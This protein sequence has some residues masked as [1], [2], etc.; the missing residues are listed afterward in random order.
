MHKGARTDPCGGRGVTRVPTATQCIG[1]A[2]TLGPYKHLLVGLTLR[3]V[4]DP[5]ERSEV[6]RQVW[7]SSRNSSA[8]SRRLAFLQSHL[9]DPQQARSPIAP[10]D[11]RNDAK[12]L[13]YGDVFLFKNY[14]LN[15]RTAGIFDTDHS[16]CAVLSDTRRKSQ[17]VAGTP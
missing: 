16:C 3:I 1:R 14:A 12:R 7:Q 9:G 5:S 4:C 2:E 15:P 13:F 8:R 11:A 17:Y 10:P 6:H